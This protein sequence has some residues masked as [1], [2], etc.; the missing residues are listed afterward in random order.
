MEAGTLY[1]HLLAT[2]SPRQLYRLH[3]APGSCVPVLTAED[4]NKR[5]SVGNVARIVAWLTDSGGFLS[6]LLFC[7]CCRQ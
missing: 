7:Y 2:L 3:K 4:L 6:T 1:F 5:T